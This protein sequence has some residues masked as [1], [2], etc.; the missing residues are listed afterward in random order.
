MS[1]ATD[2]R[3]KP[4][5]MKKEYDE[6]LAKWMKERAQAR[7]L[8]AGEKAS[9]QA[10][11]GFLGLESNSEDP[12]QRLPR[13]SRLRKRPDYHGDS[14]F[15]RQTEARTSAGPSRK[16]QSLEQE[17][18]N[19][20]T[21]TDSDLSSVPGDL[22]TP[23]GF[24]TPE[25]PT[26]DHVASDG[27]ENGTHGDEIPEVLHEHDDSSDEDETLAETT[28]L[29]ETDYEEDPDNDQGDP[30]LDLSANISQSHASA[31]KHKKEDEEAFARKMEWERFSTAVQPNDQMRHEMEL[32]KIPPQK[33]WTAEDLHDQNHPEW[34]VLALRLMYQKL[35]GVRS[36]YSGSSIHIEYSALSSAKQQAID[37]LMEGLMD[38]EASAK[39]IVRYE[40]RDF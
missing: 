22:H 25:A 32:I 3:L 24:H 20:G 7:A 35:R 17:Q 19:D 18:S 9:H 27:D 12:D 16:P 8:K 36:L 40:D 37:K 2:L 26:R 39:A 29:E 15:Q 31:A 11:K 28:D 13:P 4:D 14:K 21:A 33:V 34:F 10:S 1:K 30:T 6:K 38:P 5:E 23:E